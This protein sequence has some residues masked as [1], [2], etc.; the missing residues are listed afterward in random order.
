MKRVKKLVGLFS[1]PIC[2]VHKFFC[3]RRA[4]FPQIDVD[5]DLRGCSCLVVTSGT[6][7][8][9]NFAQKIIVT[10]QED[11]DSFAIPWNVTE[12]QTNSSPNPPSKNLTI[13]SCVSRTAANAITIVFYV[14][15]CEITFVA[16]VFREGAL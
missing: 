8:A 9:I 10:I 15:D 14:F 5:T 3:C 6:R 7:E 2:F 11:F 13:F 16:N 1:L 4:S 12:V